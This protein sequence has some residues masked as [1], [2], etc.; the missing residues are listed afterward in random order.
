MVYDGICAAKARGT[1]VILIDTAGRS[2]HNDFQMKELQEFLGV[3]SHIEKH[4]VMSATT[5]QKDAEEILEKFSVCEPSRLIFTKT[6]ETSSIG[7]ILNLLYEKKLALSY[8]TNG[9][10]VPDD[11][12]PATADMLAGLLLRDSQ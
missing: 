3:N 9:Q 4:L 11:I 12:I 10:S 6:D 7:I 5:K 8:L 1:D 2:Q